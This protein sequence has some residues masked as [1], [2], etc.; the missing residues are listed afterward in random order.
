MVRFGSN[1]HNANGN[2]MLK[3]L[4]L[5]FSLS[6]LFLANLIAQ[7]DETIFSGSY[8]LTGNIST[9]DK[10]IT[11]ANNRLGLITSHHGL[12]VTLT[13]EWNRILKPLFTHLISQ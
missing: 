3:N 12:Q 8:L 9:I 10:A 2:F 4:V 1:L 13:S 5:I 6:I 7:A 11:S